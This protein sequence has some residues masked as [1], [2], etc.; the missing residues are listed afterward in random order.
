VSHTAGTTRDYLSMPVDW[1][2]VAI[3]LIDTAGW[4]HIH[5]GEAGRDIERAADELRH[6]QW[7]RADLLVWCS[8]AD[9]REEAAAFDVRLREEFG[10]EGRPLLHVTT[11]ADLSDALSIVA[12]VR[13]SAR[14]G[15]GLEAVR[16]AVASSLQASS[17][18]EQIL[19]TTAARCRE[20][21]HGALDAL[22][23]AQDAAVA[24][25]GDELIAVELRDALEFLGRIAGRVYTDD[26][27]D[28]IFSR[29]CIGK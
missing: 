12:D 10:R 14:T 21:L 19:G 29:F 6:D 22:G 15:A 17:T 8:P 1:D 20:S 2:G 4:D 3:E 7:H 16:I 28:R 13:V 11:K 5:Q 27:L 23:R 25:V 24:G 26:I 9:I 18:A